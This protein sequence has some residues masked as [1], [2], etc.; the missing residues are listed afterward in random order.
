MILF[1]VKCLAQILINYI[2]KHVPTEYAAHANTDDYFEAIP[3]F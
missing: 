3:Y 1:S 2:K